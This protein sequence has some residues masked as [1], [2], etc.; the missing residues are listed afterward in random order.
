MAW[1]SFNSCEICA[2]A[3]SCIGRKYTLI[4][5]LLSDKHSDDQL[6]FFFA[7]DRF[8]ETEAVAVLSILV[9][10]F[11]ITI[12]EELQFAAETFEQRKTRILSTRLGFTITWVVLWMMM[13]LMLINLFSFFASFL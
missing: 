2:G 1:H 12:K 11:K 8:A 3:R 9:S 4:S 5:N 7:F 6:S 13:W 10:Q